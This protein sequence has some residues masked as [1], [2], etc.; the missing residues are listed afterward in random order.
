MA[1]IGFLV[2][3]ETMSCLVFSSCSMRGRSAVRP[4]SVLGRLEQVLGVVLDVAPVEHGVLG[5]A[6][7][8]EGRLHAREHVLH[9]AEVDVAVD[10]GDV[11]RRAAHVVLDEVAPLEHGDLG[12][13]RADVH[14]HQVA[15][16][17]PAV[18]LPAPAALEPPRRRAP[19][20]R[21][22]GPW[23]SAAEVRAG[24]AAALGPRW[25][26]DVS[27][28]GG[29]RCPLGPED[30]PGRARREPERAG[31]RRSGACA[32]A[33]RSAAS[34]S[35]TRPSMGRSGSSSGSLAIRRTPASLG[36]GR[37]A[38]RPPTDRV[39]AS[40]APTGAAEPHR[41][42]GAV[43]T[44]RRRPHGASVAARPLTS[45]GATR[46]TPSRTRRRGSA[47]VSVQGLI[48][49]GHRKVFL[50]MRTLRE[51]AAGTSPTPGG[52][53][54]GRRRVRSIGGCGST[55]WV[56]SSGSAI[57][58]EA[59]RQQLAGTQ[60]PGLGGEIGQQDGRTVV[61]GGIDAQGEDGGPEVVDGLVALAGPGQGQRRAAR[62]LATAASAC[63]VVTPAQLDPPRAAR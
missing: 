25:P 34:R 31:C 55:R 39:D 20:G 30:R 28:A 11:V 61:R 43:G 10:L 50:L 16:D 33:T 23:P 35:W 58:R 1:P 29:P 21:R 24:L 59:R 37:G 22:H 36:R 17:R 14:A 60:R 47:A 57:V 18:A 15:P 51:H 63:P 62:A 32:R 5:R 12:E 13:L 19:P 41:S 27:V 49:L 3:W 45:S 52:A 4:R 9:P 53:P 26:T 7:V 48:V 56:M 2:T 8:D 40:P 46:R 6:D 54:G 44:P 38:R 42:D